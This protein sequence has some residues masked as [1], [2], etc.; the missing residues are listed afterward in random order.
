MTEFL[1][2]FT[3]LFGLLVAW[4]YRPQHMFHDWRYQVKGTWT[5]RETGNRVSVADYR[6]CSKCP[7]EESMFNDHQ[8]HQVEP[9]AAREDDVTI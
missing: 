3:V 6:V 5:I 1:I 9:Q 4:H 8:W 2:Y 7:R